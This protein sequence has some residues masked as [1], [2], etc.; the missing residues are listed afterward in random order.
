MMFDGYRIPRANCQ[1]K[2]YEWY[3]VLVWSGMKPNPKYNA[4]LENL[5]TNSYFLSLIH[6]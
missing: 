3:A 6:I 5:N 1:A 4:K 2:D